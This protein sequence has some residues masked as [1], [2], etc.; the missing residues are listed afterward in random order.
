MTPLSMT[1]SLSNAE[2]PSR[3]VDGLL[4]AFTIA[5]LAFIPFVIVTFMT[6]PAVTTVCLVAFMAADLYD[7]VLA[8]RLDADGP[9]RRALDSIVDRLAIDA[10]L[11]AACVAGAL[12]L[13][14]LI[15][16]LARD[17]Y[18][19]VLCERMMRTRHVA[20]KTDLVYRGLSFL[21]AMWAIAAPFLSATTRTALAAGLLAAAV[22]VALDLTRSVRLVLAAPPQVMH[23]VIPASALRRGSIAEIAPRSGIAALDAPSLVA[24]PLMH[25]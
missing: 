8:R 22:L 23:R 10:C 7:G 12:P 24:R 4:T 13:P 5:R 20:I 3:T 21:I 9:R 2:P 1:E 15:G 6:A 17:L 16:F 14:L 11:I 18:C 25:A 19:S